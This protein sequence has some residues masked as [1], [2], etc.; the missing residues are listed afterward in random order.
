M[1][2]FR[3][4]Q[5]ALRGQ[6]VPV[7]ATR[8]GLIIGIG[9]YRDSRLN[10]RCASADAKAMHQLMTDAD[11]GLFSDENVRLLLD[12][13]A[14]R[15]NIWLELANLCRKA[16]PDDTVW[17]YFAGHGALE[18]SRSF[19]VTHNADVD[20]LRGTAL[21]QR[22]LV[23]FLDDI[24][25]QRLLVLL[26]C[27][28]AAAT[29]ARKNATRA[30]IAAEAVLGAFKGKGRITLSSSDG[31]EKSVELTDCGH[32]AFTYFLERG[33]R[34]EADLDGD[35][36]VTVDELWRFLEDKVK[37]AS[38][39]VG[40]PQTPVLIG[41]LTHDFA[42]TL[43]PIVTQEK[44]RLAEAIKERS[45]LGD[46]KLNTEEG[47]F[48]MDLLRFGARNPAG[49][50]VLG[51]LE[52]FIRGSLRLITFRSLIRA[53]RLSPPP[54]LLVAP[55][56]RD[57]V[58]L[59]STGPATPVRR[60]RPPPAR[61]TDAQQ[62]IESQ[63]AWVSF[64]GCGESM[65]DGAGLDW[66]LVP[67]GLMPLVL[68]EGEHPEWIEIK[69]PFWITR[70]AADDRAI[71]QLFQSAADRGVDRF[72]RLLSTTT[73]L[74]RTREGFTLSAEDL[75]ALCEVLSQ[76]QGTRIRLPSEVEWSAGVELFVQTGEGNGR[77]SWLGVESQAGGLEW[78]G[79]TFGPLRA[80]LW[81]TP[82]TFGLRTSLVLRSAGQNLRRNGGFASPMSIGGARLVM[83]ISE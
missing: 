65:M 78:T 81:K 13:E 8:H 33:L 17:I 4:I 82:A 48:C 41:E 6:V 64:L 56:T 36:V 45:G 19:W 71:R 79:T 66:V 74:R 38:Q 16:G 61:W 25:A 21:D 80:Q 68:Q 29:A 72:A 44:G 77:K 35:G 20:N 69:S 43:N 75:G 67:A 30:T 2:N 49:H 59:T 26:D 14:T 28:H 12:A 27:C 57:R 10:L 70:S 40:E 34:G 24:P 11:C 58:L 63:R 32:G 5:V 47:Q 73:F 51:E 31:R 42:L 37:D 46:D 9:Q 18:G 55:E 62:M 1:T 39:A 3:D 60:Q 54:G 52:S 53:A 50:D 22:H 7:G 15:E 76:Q 23:D 83:E